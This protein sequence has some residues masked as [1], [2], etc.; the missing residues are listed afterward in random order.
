MTVEEINL[1]KDFGPVIALI[2]IMTTGGKWVLQKAFEQIESA[3]KDFSNYVHTTEKEHT[4]AMNK[5]SNNLSNLTVD[6]DSHIKMKDEFI[7][8]INLQRNTIDDQRKTINELF[9]MLKEQIKTNR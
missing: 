2:I 6:L 4:D 9:E 1:F 8:T 5:I 7:D 3:R